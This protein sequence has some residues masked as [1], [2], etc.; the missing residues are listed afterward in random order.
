LLLQP[1]G[2]LIESQRPQFQGRQGFQPPLSFPPNFIKNPPHPPSKQ[3]L[4]IVGVF[5]LMMV[6]AL[7][8]ALEIARKWQKSIQ[9]AARAEADK[10][11]AELSFLKAQ[12]NPHFLFNTLNNIYSLAVIKSEV[13]ADS[14]M[15]LSNIMRY[16]TDEATEDFVPLQDEINCLTD[17][18]ELQRLRLGKKVT[19]EYDI[20]G[21]ASYK[22][23]TPLILM[24]FIENVFKY[25]TSNHE[26]S[27]I[28]IKIIVEELTVNLFTSNKIFIHKESIERKGVG[29]ANTIK[30]LQ[31]L[32]P[33]RFLLNIDDSNGE[34]KV[35]LTLQ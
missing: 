12:I 31:H 26:P 18:I 9:D 35:H 11:N 3:R 15:K 24:P 17:Y 22:K 27:T 5:I 6:L 34:Y 23:I 14:I 25:G 13:T 1:F 29:I 8:F 16:V 2:T 21:D 4:D 7:S 30:R 20:S 10:A 32:Y 19:L 28:T 33:N